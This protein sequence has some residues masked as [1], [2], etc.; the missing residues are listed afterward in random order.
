MKKTLI[1]MFLGLALSAPV[2]AASLYTQ[3]SPA[4]GA[5]SGS[6]VVS[7]IDDMEWSIRHSSVAQTLDATSRDK[8]LA[9]LQRARAE[10]AEGNLRTAQELVRRA[11]RPLVEMAP[12]AMSG[13]HPSDLDYVVDIKATMA[14]II[15]TAE[16]IAIEKSA[17]T[18]FVAAARAALREGEALAKAGRTEEA[19]TVVTAAYGRLQAEVARLRSGDEF[20]LDVPKGFS[21]REWADALRR[22][23]ERMQLSRYLLIEA[24]SEGVDSTPLLSGIAAAE[25]SLSEAT[26]L[27]LN[28]RWEQAYRS[29]D[30]AYLQMEA[31]WKEVGVEW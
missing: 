7:Q 28:D 17:S 4:G 12:T 10:V 27:A 13:K 14:S 5:A 25:T 29:L 9:L 1:S 31:S 19:N 26:R 8:S 18:D 3:P 6:L 22:F 15:D 30:L 20:V 23:D 21:D 24:Q 16:Q 2:V 11:G